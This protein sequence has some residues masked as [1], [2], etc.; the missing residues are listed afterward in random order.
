MKSLEK[1]VL[2]AE[3]FM[4]TYS[5]MLL[6]NE[7][8]EGVIRQRYIDA[9]NEVKKVCLK[10]K[11]ALHIGVV[12]V[13]TS[14]SSRVLEKLL[15]TGDRPPISDIDKFALDLVIAMNKGLDLNFGP[16]K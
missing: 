16:L 15:Y 6:G 1:R 9:F 13:G 14:N 8:R 7:K 12:N 4:N 11:N 2:K 3:F 10:Y 5:E